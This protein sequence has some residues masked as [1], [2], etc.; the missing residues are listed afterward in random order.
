M[1]LTVFFFTCFKAGIKL[2]VCRLFSCQET[3]YK[4]KQL[5]SLEVLNT[6]TLL[7]IHRFSIIDLDLTP[8]IPGPSGCIVHVSAGSVSTFLFQQVNGGIDNTSDRTNQIMSNWG[9]DN[10]C[11]S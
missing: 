5:F 3:S 1:Y 8:S 6:V 4:L 11:D 9:P 7:L 2:C 10:A